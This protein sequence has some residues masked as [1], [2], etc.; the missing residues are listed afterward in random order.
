MKTIPP[1]ETIALR[2]SQ[3]IGSP[4]SLVIHTIFFIAIFCLAF[5][6]F[7]LDQILLILTTLV[8]LEAIYLAIFIQMTVNQ[9]AKQIE[10]VSEDVE[11]LSENIDGI[12]EDVEEIS[13]DIDTIQGDVKEISEDVE[14]ISEDVEEL[15]EEIEKDDRED[16][17]EQ[18]ESLKHIDRI[19]NSLQALLQEIQDM[20]R[21]HSE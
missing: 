19:E 5:F 13:K 17:A 15:S 2:T 21:H 7:S 20:K 11:E 4:P 8:S 18:L 9:H 16:A 14:E 10:E 1:L 12:G 3:Y 6:G